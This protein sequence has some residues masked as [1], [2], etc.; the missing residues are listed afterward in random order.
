MKRLEAELVVDCRCALGE[1]P[2]WDELDQRLWWTDI[3]SSKLHRYD[4]ASGLHHVIETDFPVGC[5]T[6]VEGENRMLAAGVGG[7]YWLNPDTGRMKA[8]VNP[9]QLLPDERFNDGKCDN[10]GRFLTGTM[11]A[12][13]KPEGAFYSIDHTLRMKRL[14]DRVACSNGIAW[15]PDDSTLYYIDSLKYSVMAFDYDIETGSIRNGKMIINYQDSGCLPDG[16]TSD[17][18]G[19]LWIAEWGGGKVSC[20]DPSAGKK[21]AEVHVP[22]SFV[23]S[24]VFAGDH[25]NELY[26]TTAA[27]HDRSPYAGGVFRVKTDRKGRYMNR[28]KFEE[29]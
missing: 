18:E 27:N 10:R 9:E 7:V 2:L 14:F 23:T 20:W 16:M 17:S 5:F 13:G 29:N 3:A 24:C 6:L 25:M 15:S 19:M 1:G 4:P 8:I 12:D 21:Q 22:C 28:Y 11:T 26:I